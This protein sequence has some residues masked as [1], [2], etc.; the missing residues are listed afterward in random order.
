MF[1]QSVRYL[2]TLYSSTVLCKLLFLCG[3]KP[4]IF[5]GQEKSTDMTDEQKQVFW[6]HFKVLDENRVKFEKPPANWKP[7]EVRDMNDEELQAYWGAFRQIMTNA[8]LASQQEQPD[9]SQEDED[10]R[11]VL[12]D[13]DQ[14]DI[15]QQHD[16]HD[17]CASEPPAKRVCVRVRGKTN[18]AIVDERSSARLQKLLVSKPKQR[19]GKPNAVQKRPYKQ[20]VKVSREGKHSCISIWAKVQLFK[21]TRISIYMMYC[22]SFIDKNTFVATML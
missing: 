18:P 5:A 17:A 8:S 20:S 9:T 3:S 19:K 13:H 6:D 1:E 11:I 10:T 2:V 12:A 7:Q 14:L 4:I 16:Q 22:K 21:D 15:A